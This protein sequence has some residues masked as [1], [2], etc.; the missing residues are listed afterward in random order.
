MTSKKAWTEYDAATAAAVDR[1]FAK[2]ERLTEEA[3]DVYWR[4]SMNQR[5][6]PMDTWVNR[7]HFRNS[8]GNLAKALGWLSERLGVCVLQV[9]DSGS[10]GPERGPYTS[11]FHLRL[12]DANGDGD[13]LTVVIPRADFWYENVVRKAILAATGLLVPDHHCLHWHDLTTMVWRCAEYPVSEF[14]LPTSG[15]LQDLQD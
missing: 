1:G 10:W 13:E 7:D 8:I 4:N 2:T 14:N 12:L 9:L 3:L 15:H 5:G 6:W 11:E